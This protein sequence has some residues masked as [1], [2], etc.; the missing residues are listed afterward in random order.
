MLAYGATVS[1]AGA[2]V[3]LGTLQSW[4]FEVYEE[5]DQT[6]RVPGTRLFAQSASLSG[7]QFG[8]I[9]QRAFVWPA[10]TQ[11]RVF[12]TLAQI[13]PTT[14]TPILRQFSDQLH[15]AYWNAGYRSGAG[16]GNRFYDD[17]AHLVVALAEAYRLTNDPVYLDRAIDTYSFVL[18]GEDSAAGGGI[19]FQQFN[20]YSKDAIS[21]LQGARGAAMLYQ[22]TGQQSYLDD[23]T[24]LLDWA[25]S[26]IQQSN[27]LFYQGFIISTNMPGGVNLVNSAG[28]GI[29]A[30]LE[31]YDATGDEDYLTEAQ[32][33]ATETLT[34][35]FDS[36]TGR[37]NPEGYWAFELVDALNNLYLHDR[38]PL[39][40]S[41]VNTAMAWLHDNKR[42]PNGHYDVFWGRN[43]PLVG[44]F[45]SWN[46]NEQAAVARAY[47]YSSIDWSELPNPLLGDVN[48]DGILSTLDFQ[49]FVAGWLVD[50]SSFS[51]FNKIKAGDLNLDGRTGVEDFVRLR[52]ALSNAGV[53]IDP[54]AWQAANVVP[55]PHSLWFAVVG[56]AL[57]IAGRSGAR[58]AAWEYRSLRGQD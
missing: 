11:F 55:E 44:E 52:T 17:N 51:D 33:I 7:E 53:V 29:S 37:L 14:Y 28:D 39:W 3:D 32:R 23:A 16:G 12:N 1:S 46:L 30:N 47:L 15:A 35:Y 18:E 31:I 4:G 34:R 54:G 9:N 6:L 36:A 2:Q 25:N 19:Y 10:S 22:A 43:G 48:Q 57:F 50:T 27:G 5:I 49:D 58:M 42:D 21:T 13:E 26:H 24:R 20:D 56:F 41:K 8:G 45:S 40:L 38:N